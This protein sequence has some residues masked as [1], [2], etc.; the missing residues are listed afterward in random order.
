MFG[1]Q[2]RTDI[3]FNLKPSRPIRLVLRRRGVDSPEGQKWWP[4]NQLEIRFRT[5]YRAEIFTRSI[6]HQDHSFLKM[7]AQMDHAKW[8]IVREAGGEGLNE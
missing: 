6:S 2:L 7:S 4:A 5:I 3:G 8:Q 1:Q